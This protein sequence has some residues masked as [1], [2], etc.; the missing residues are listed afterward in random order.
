M[1]VLIS[2][3]NRAFSLNTAIIILLFIIIII[4]FI[5]ITSILKYNNTNN[6][7]L[8]DIIR[9]KGGLEKLC[10]SILYQL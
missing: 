4:Q 1:I 7:G 3:K 5:I 6:I 2:K 9:I 8:R 10:R